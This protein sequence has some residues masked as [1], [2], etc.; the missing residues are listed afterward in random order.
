M[1]AKKKPVAEIAA[2]M[3]V[4]LLMPHLTCRDCGKAK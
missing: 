1:T 2:E 4:N 3:G